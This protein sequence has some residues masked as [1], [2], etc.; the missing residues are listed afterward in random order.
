MRLIVFRICLPRQVAGVVS[1]PFQ[2]IWC[3]EKTSCQVVS[4]E[5]AVAEESS[6]SSSGIL[7]TR[8]LTGTQSSF[9]GS[10]LGCCCWLSYTFVSC[11]LVTP[12]R[13]G[14]GWWHLAE[15]PDAS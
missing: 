13:L 15:P 6:W 1:I 14:F 9:A 5:P 7:I 10:S 12:G 8:S 4:M 3:C 2:Q 11:R